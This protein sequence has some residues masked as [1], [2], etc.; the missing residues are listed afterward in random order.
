MYCKRGVRK[1]TFRQKSAID[2]HNKRAFLGLPTNK[3]SIAYSQGIHWPVGGIHGYSL[4][5]W[6]HLLL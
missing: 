3:R 4:I 1:V 5:I 2:L 6:E